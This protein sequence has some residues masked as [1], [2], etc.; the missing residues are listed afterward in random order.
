MGWFEGALVFVTGLIVFAVI[1]PVGQSLLPDMQD[2][3]GPTVVVMVSTMF[4]LILVL[5]FFMFFK[6]SQEPD[7]FL[8]GGSGEQF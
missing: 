6:Q 2:T 8:M 7:H 3:M 1:L 4:V 5:I